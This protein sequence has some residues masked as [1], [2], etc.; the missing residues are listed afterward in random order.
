MRENLT[1]ITNKNQLRLNDRIVFS[2]Q[3][4]GIIRLEYATVAF[5]HEKEDKTIA[6][7]QLEKTG[8]FGVLDYTEHVAF[9]VKE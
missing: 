6:V 4:K 3:G 9:K 5:L 7:Y 1:R 8:K 2:N